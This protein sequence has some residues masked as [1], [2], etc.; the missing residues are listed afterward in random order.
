[1]SNTSV[2]LLSLI[3]GLPAL[4][5]GLTLIA[6]RR[7]DRWG[8]VLSTTLVAGSF[9]L[10]ATLWWRMLR[11][12]EVDRPITATLYSWIPVDRLQVDAALRLDQLSICFALLITG[13]GLLI[14]IYSIGYMHHDEGFGK[15]F[16]YLNLFLFFMLLLVWL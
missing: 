15:F 14:H 13:V 16:A 5:A 12:D 1:M 6:G 4:G 11:R 10:T 2:Q 9:L 8:H 3:P 7:A